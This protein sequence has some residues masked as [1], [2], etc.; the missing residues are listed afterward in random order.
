MAR[1][2]RLTIRTRDDLQA[3][4]GMASWLRRPPVRDVII[5]IPSIEDDVCRQAAKA[6]RRH[7]NDCGCFWGAPAF[8]L[9]LLALLFRGGA[10]TW[11][12]VTASLGLALAAGAGGK[13]LGL[14]WSRSRLLA[15][16]RRLDPETSAHA[17]SVRRRVS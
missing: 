7:F 17:L 13:L 16:L 12:G 1:L 9:A 11:T 3:T 14:A 10:H 8:L 2:H 15:W 4:A 5:D 6:L